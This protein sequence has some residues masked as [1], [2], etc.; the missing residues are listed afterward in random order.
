[1]HLCALTLEIVENAYT[2]GTYAIKALLKTQAVER[3][4]SKGEAGV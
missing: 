1:M 4:G 3:A 2:L